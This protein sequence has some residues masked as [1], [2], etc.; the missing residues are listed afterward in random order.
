[1]GIV[2]WFLG[3]H[4]SWRITPTLVSVHL[5]QSGFAT[6]S[7]KSFSRQTS[8]K[9][10]TATPYQLGIPIDSIDPS[11]DANDCPTQLWRKEAYQSLIGSIGWLLSTTRPDL[12]TVHFF[13]SS[14]TYKPASGHMK[15]ALY[16]L[17]YIHSTH[18]F[19]ILF[20]L[21]DIAPM[22]SY[23]HFPPSTDIEAYNDVVPCKLGCSN[24]LS[25]YS[26]A[27]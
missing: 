27:C 25:A 20:T 22:P 15:A 19:G 24:T 4:F 7:V 8:N 12:V 10:P 23:V 16:A 1:M 11:I 13:L 17:Y 26:D 2:E 21:D 6:N 18:N 14:Y 3:V 9:T 5:N